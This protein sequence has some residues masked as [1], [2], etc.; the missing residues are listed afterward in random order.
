MHHFDGA[1]G[2]T[3][4]HG[5]Q[6]GLARPIG[7]LVESSQGILHDA[8]LGLLARE[9]HL[10]SLA[11]EAGVGV[12]RHR[13]GIFLRG[14]REGGDGLE[15]D[16]ARGRGRC[17]SISAPAGLHGVISSYICTHI[18]INIY[19]D[20]GMVAKAGGGS[21]TSHSQCG[22]PPRRRQHLSSASMDRMSDYKVDQ[23]MA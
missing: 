13:G 19:V 20:I 11:G 18:Y 9:R 8:L 23:G 21:Q 15:G 17:A 2:E 22:Y 5:P 14:R 4:S 6:R 16:S 12:R 7:D 3:E 10:F 1:A